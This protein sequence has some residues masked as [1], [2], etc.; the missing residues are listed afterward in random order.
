[1]MIV[2]PYVITWESI[3]KKSLETSIEIPK[4]SQILSFEVSEQDLIVNVLVDIEQN[5][6]HSVPIK[7]VQSGI[8]VSDLCDSKLIFNQT[9]RFNNK[10]YHIFCNEYI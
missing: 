9:V 6:S 7:L 8:D 5:E 10:S 4:Y 3:K 1:M 2:K